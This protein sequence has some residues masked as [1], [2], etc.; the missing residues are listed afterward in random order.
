M[1]GMGPFGVLASQAFFTISS[2]NSSFV[3]QTLMLN[4]GKEGEKQR[5]LKRLKLRGRSGTSV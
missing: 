2:L 1:P 4:G 5:R 3:V